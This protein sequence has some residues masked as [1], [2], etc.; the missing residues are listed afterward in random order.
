LIRLGRVA[1][2][3]ISGMSLA[4]GSKVASVQHPIQI[5]QENKK[6]RSDQIRPGL[7]ILAEDFKRAIKK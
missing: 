6:A 2:R 3:C 7:L 4:V 5:V 1:L